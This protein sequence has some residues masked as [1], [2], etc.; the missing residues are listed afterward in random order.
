[1]AILGGI[2]S[3]AGPVLGATIITLLPELLRGFKDFRLMINGAD[4]GGDRAVPAEGHLGSAADAQLVRRLAFTQ[5]CAAGGHG[6]GRV[7]LMLE[8]A[9]VSKRFGGLTVLHDVSFSV[10]AGSIFGLIGPNGAGKTTVFNLATGLLAPSGGTIRFEG[11]DLPGRA[12]HAITRLGLARTFQNI[13]IFKEM[14]LLDNVLVGQHSHLGYG[15]AGCAAFAAGLSATGA[16]RTRTRARTA[17]VGRARRRRRPT[18]PTTCRTVT[19]A[20]SN[21][22]GHWR[23]S[24]SCCCS[25]SRSPA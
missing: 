25:T 23:P 6:S 1:M 8:L 14:T 5:V 2:G 4:S 15:I 19:S 21:S 7:A 18:S 17:V 10:P 9:N 3:I 24:R 11:A 13:R 12:P 20:G 22:P 16:R